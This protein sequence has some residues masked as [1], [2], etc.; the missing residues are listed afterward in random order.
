MTERT[1]DWCA[2][3]DSTLDG[4]YDEPGPC[5]CGMP[6]VIATVWAGTA[7]LAGAFILVLVCV[8]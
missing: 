8:L 7:L 3:D 6:T 4:F 2:C 1:P 5:P